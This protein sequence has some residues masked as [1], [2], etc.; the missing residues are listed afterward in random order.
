[1]E[2]TLHHAIKRVNP[3]RPFTVTAEG[4]RRIVLGLSSTGLKG[5]IGD[6]VDVSLIASGQAH[7]QAKPLRSTQ[8]ARVS[9]RTAS[10]VRELV[11]GA[12][13]DRELPAG[14][15]PDSVAC[16]LTLPTEAF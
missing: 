1:M 11:E 15:V 16:A 4:L 13:A 9:A 8:L 10:R 7:H 14:L 12:V 3:R 5:E 2:S 6:V